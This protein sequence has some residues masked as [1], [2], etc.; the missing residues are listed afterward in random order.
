ML[1]LLLTTIL[2]V[3][4]TGGCLPCPVSG[5]PLEPSRHSGKLLLSVLFF[6]PPFLKNTPND[7]FEPLLL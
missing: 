4:A 5:P 1:S 2:A 6:F 3:Q 7:S